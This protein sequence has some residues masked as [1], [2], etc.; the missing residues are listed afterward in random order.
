MEEKKKKSKKKKLLIAGVATPVLI[1]VFSAVTIVLLPKILWDKAWGAVMAAIEAVIDT[2]KGVAQWLGDP[3]QPDRE[4]LALMR[5]KDA[6]GF[7]DL[8][9]F[10]FLFALDQDDDSENPYAKLKNKIS[11]AFSKMYLSESD[12]VTLLDAL[13][14]PAT[15]KADADYVSTHFLYKPQIRLELTAEEFAT[16]YEQ[17]FEVLAHSPITDKLIA[18]YRAYKAPG[19]KMTEDQVRTTVFVRDS[20]EDGRFSGEDTIWYLHE[21]FDTLRRSGEYSSSYRYAPE[22][23]D[24]KGNPINQQQELRLQLFE[25]CEWTTELRNPQDGSID[26]DNLQLLASWWRHY[27]VVF[28][29]SPVAS[30]INGKLEEKAKGNTEGNKDNKDNNKVNKSDISYI[31]E[32]PIIDKQSQAYSIILEPYGEYSDANVSFI[33]E[34]ERVRYPGS[35]E[36]FSPEQ[37]PIMFQ[38]G[39]KT[40]I[41]TLDAFLLKN[42]KVKTFST[43]SYEDETRKFGVDWQMMYAA[44]VLYG[45][46]NEPTGTD[47]EELEKQ[48]K[49]IQEQQEGGAEVDKDSGTLKIKKSVIRAMAKT[50]KDMEELEKNDVTS[51]EAI[52]D[53]L[54][55]NE[56]YRY[57]D[58]N[59]K[60]LAHQGWV[61]WNAVTDLTHEERSEVLF[62]GVT[63]NAYVPTYIPRTYK[64]ALCDVVYA[65]YTGGERIEKYTVTYHWDTFANELKKKGIDLN[66]EKIWEKYKKVLE[67]LPGGER[68]IAKLEHV[69]KFSG[70]EIQEEMAY[71]VVF[72]NY[73]RVGITYATAELAIN[74]E[75]SLPYPDENGGSTCDDVRAETDKDNNII[76][77]DPV[78]SFRARTLSEEEIDLI[79]EKI[80]DQFPTVFPDSKASAGTIGYTMIKTALQSVGKITYRQGETNRQGKE[81]YVKVFTNN[82]LDYAGPV[83]KAEVGA[84]HDKY[85]DVPNH[86]YEDTT[87]EPVTSY[88]LFGS[89]YK[90]DGWPLGL[91]FPQSSVN[92]L[93]PFSFNEDGEWV[94]TPLRYPYS[95][96]CSS[97]VDI[98]Y[99]AALI[100]AT[101]NGNYKNAFINEKG[102]FKITSDLHE[103]VTNIWETQLNDGTDV[104]LRYQC[105]PIFYKV[106][107]DDEDLSALRDAMMKDQTLLPGDLILS[108]NP[109]KTKG[110]VVI[111]LGW[112]YYKYSTGYVWLPLV[113]EMRGTENGAR[114][115]GGN[116]YGASAISVLSANSIKKGEKSYWRARLWVDDK[117]AQLPLF[118][119]LQM[120]TTELSNQDFMIKCIEAG[121]IPY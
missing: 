87:N 120:K 27:G 90:K 62:E 17:A 102:A 78:D 1:A 80:H 84:Y 15:T 54:K 107:S 74:A 77:H 58:I 14:D 76:S 86:F 41:Y 109:G 116:T 106:S 97:Y 12:M 115:A 43:V 13:Y 6:D 98:L 57:A 119:L 60:S 59:Q 121:I 11:A 37:N 71:S 113:A 5:F 51:I 91:L 40:G 32:E 50:F 100:S 16:I 65:S 45:R 108:A 70:T 66:D 111:F 34:L 31:G 81:G 89:I 92:T 88:G 96:D 82:A 75:D 28:H 83:L 61:K 93:S 94:N 8:Y 48:I 39:S 69:K 105:E 47:K 38:E 10:D 29:Y 4:Q 30:Y 22:Y 49:A 104:A 67:E 53:Y 21:D 24:E 46:G 19:S 7:D 85:A 55:E 26:R 99:T 20:N 101:G 25:V 56:L 72:G 35:N 36:K 42:G 23:V 44:L 64:S 110:H 118:P 95:A 18:D 3:N 52:N 112:T 117:Y 73:E 114:V 103:N 33:Y 2:G 79:L 63:S 68:I 9:S